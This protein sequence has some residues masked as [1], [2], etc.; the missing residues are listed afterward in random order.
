MRVDMAVA[1]DQDGS[2]D[3]DPSNVMT[4]SMP[5]RRSRPGIESA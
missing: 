1:N 2:T 3:V 5:Q 4:I